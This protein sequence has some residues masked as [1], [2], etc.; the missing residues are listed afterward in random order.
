MCVCITRKNEGASD[1][2]GCGVR[3]G[4]NEKHYGCCLLVS[5]QNVTM[6]RNSNEIIYEGKHKFDM[7]RRTQDKYKIRVAFSSI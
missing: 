3:V 6:Y 5:F 4:L 1:G 2:G 7:L